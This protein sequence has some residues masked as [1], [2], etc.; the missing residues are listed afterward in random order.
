MRKLSLMDLFEVLTVGLPFC[1]FKIIFGLYLLRINFQLLGISILVWGILDLII[2][3]INFFSLVT[4]KRRILRVCGLNYL[5]AIILPVFPVVHS[6]PK[7]LGTGIDA[8]FSFII[9]SIVIGGGVFGELSYLEIKIWSVGVILNV[10][11]AGI[12]RLLNTTKRIKLSR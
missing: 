3:V 12:Y 10:L 6:G 4:F 11:S 7:D 2:N 1:S 5:V 8:M 9:V